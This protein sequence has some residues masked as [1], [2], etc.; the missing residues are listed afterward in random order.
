[1]MVFWNKV[2]SYSTLPLYRNAVYLMLNTAA[3]S[4]LGFFFWLI[5]ARIF[6]ENEVGYSSAIISAIFFLASI[7]LLGLNWSLVR[8]LPQTDKPV[9]LINSS[10]MVGGLFAVFVSMIF[11]AGLALWSPALQF[12]GEKFLFAL[13]FIGSVALSVLSILTDNVLLAGRRAFYILVKDVSVS[14][15]KIALAFGFAIS[16][17]S[18]GVIASWGLALGVGFIVSTLIFIPKVQAGYKPM[19][20]LD[21]SVIRTMWR[22]SGSSY[23]TN[24]LSSAERF[25][26]P[27]MVLNL[28]GTY[29][30]AYFYIAWM[31]GGLI[32]SIP[33]S[34]G[35]SL[36]S[37]ISNY[38]ND[39]DVKHNVVRSLKLNYI[40]LIPAL[41]V[42]LA[43]SK[44]LL[45]A[46]G[47]GYEA[48][49]LTL[50]WLLSFSSLFI[51][52]SSVYTSILKAK[53]RMVEFFTIRALS[54]IAVLTLSYVLLPATGIVGVGYVYIGV[55][56]LMTIVLGIKLYLFV[57]RLNGY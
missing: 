52:I 35:E 25:I 5:V 13:T 33:R 1:M 41:V 3:T 56:G 17:H 2:T 44:W 14:F 11:V 57:K 15:L 31:M 7:S 53:D 9:K 12:I 39:E 36:F 6:S 54:S 27:L 47:E 29:S 4:L 19:P 28:L 34:T 50:L 38:Q 32:A 51:G 37:E 48:N 16:F 40:L 24:L 45:L 22:Y 18:F 20:S 21:I 49:A 55:Q 8:F 10:F 30:S 46:F 23:L 42:F 26:L 43:A